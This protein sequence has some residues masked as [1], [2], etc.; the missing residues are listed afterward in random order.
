MIIPTPIKIKSTEEIRQILHD[1]GLSDAV[2][3]RKFYISFNEVIESHEALRARCHSLKAQIKPALDMIRGLISILGNNP[4][5]WVKW[6]QRTETIL[7]L[8]EL[9]DT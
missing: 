5:I 6:I 2:K 7:K 8:S 9:D 3:N 1:V 4:D